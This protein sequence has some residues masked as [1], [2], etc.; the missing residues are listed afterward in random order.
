[1]EMLSGVLD[2]GIYNAISYMYFLLTAL[3]AVVGILLGT[4][5]KG[6]F[7]MPP[8][9]KSELTLGEKLTTAL[10]TPCTILFG[11]YVVLQLAITQILSM[12]MV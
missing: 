1:M 6:C 3:L 7:S 8:D 10:F 5:V 12:V 9:E 11:L 2:S 4:R